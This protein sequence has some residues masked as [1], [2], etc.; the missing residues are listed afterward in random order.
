MHILEKIFDLFD[1]R[2]GE[3][4]FG[5]PVSQLEHALQ[6]AALAEAAGAPEALILAGLLH[7]I[8]HLLHKLPENIAN[9]GVD[10]RHETIGAAW[11]SRYFPAG[12][13]DPVRL[14]VAAKRYLCATDNA[15]FAR[16]SAAS[17]QS[18]ALQGGPMTEAEV[19]EFETLPSARAGVQL[20][21]WD[22]MAKIVGQKTPGLSQ[23]RTLLEQFLL[24]PAPEPKE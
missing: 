10:A 9:Q 17:V 22:D 20:R 1:R 5:E 14:H 11:L 3:A 18:L 2:G 16:L 12:V 19:R 6:T 13:A 8:G 24:H 21:L 23:Y 15:Y 7:D 4:Y